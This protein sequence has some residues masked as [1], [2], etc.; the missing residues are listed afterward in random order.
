MIENIFGQIALIAF[1][2]ALGFGLYCVYEEAK[3]MRRLFWTMKN[4]KS[5]L[6]GH[7]LQNFKWNGLAEINFP[8]VRFFLAF[9]FE[10]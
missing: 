8:L 10:L 1:T 4:T 7:G 9:F 5:A 2:G 3:N 6:N